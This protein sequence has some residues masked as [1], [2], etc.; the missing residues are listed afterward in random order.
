MTFHQKRY[1]ENKNKQ[2]AVETTL[3]AMQ[4]RNDML[5][6]AS[7]KHRDTEAHFK[8]PSTHLKALTHLNS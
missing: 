8:Q 5:H 1:I 6:S 7:W 4:N 3:N 2:K